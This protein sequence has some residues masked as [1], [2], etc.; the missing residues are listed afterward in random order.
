MTESSP[1]DIHWPI[2]RCC[3]TPFDHKPPGEDDEPCACLPLERA[4]RGWI[5]RDLPPMTPEQREACLSEIDRVEGHSRDHY[6]GA[7]DATLASG[8][9]SAW[10]DFCRDKGLL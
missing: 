4:L 3:M 6:Q 8:V 1:S 2:T 5:R 7:D 9:L 10:T